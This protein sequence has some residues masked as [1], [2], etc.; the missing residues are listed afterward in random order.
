M[1]LSALLCLVMLISLFS[2][3]Q[4]RSGASTTKPEG[5]TPEVTPPEITT[6]GKTD[7][8]SSSP[9]SNEDK[10]KFIDYRKE[11]VGADVTLE[12]FDTVYMYYGEYGGSHVFFS[13]REIFNG[14][15]SQNDVYSNYTFDVNGVHF[16]GTR[17]F[18]IIVYNGSEA[19]DIDQ[20]FEKGYISAT[21]VEDVAEIHNATVT[22]YYHS[23]YIEFEHDQ[24]PGAMPKEKLAE[25]KAVA[26][27]IYSENG[28]I[29]VDLVHYGTYGDR[30]VFFLT[31][32][33]NPNANPITMYFSTYDKPITYCG[34]FYLVVYEYGGGFFNLSPMEICKRSLLT[35]E[36]V[37]ELCAYHESRFTDH[38]H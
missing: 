30:A 33:D 18:R 25:F 32:G 8:P 38:P 29:N 2:C 3:A 5:T 23:Y 28:K 16:F 7:P 35:E 13:Q 37:N 31:V 21:D 22:P 4:K 34:S 12:D 1:L 26:D 10:Q 9:L 17:K 24:A 19:L 6:E 36:E 11:A 14:H 15:V 20:A 27:K